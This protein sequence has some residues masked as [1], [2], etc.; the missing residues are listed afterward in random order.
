LLPST[1]FKDEL[2]LASPE[3]K[4]ALQKEIQHNEQVTNLSQMADCLS[5]NRTSRY[6]EAGIVY[7]SGTGFKKC[8][9]IGLGKLEPDKK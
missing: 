5:T 9:K 4:E 7:A 8:E 6:N 2:T 3:F 1:E